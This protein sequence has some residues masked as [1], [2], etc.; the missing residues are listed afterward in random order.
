VSPA[1]QGLCAAVATACGVSRPT[2][3]AGRV[4]WDEFVRLV[5]RHQVGTLV[6][7]S[8]WLAEVGA[9][10]GAHAELLRRVEADAYRW[11]RL[12]ALLR[13]VLS[14]LADTGIDVV[15]LKGVTAALDGHGDPSARSSGDLDVL[16]RPESVAAAVSALRSAGLDWYGW[17]LPEDP[18][19]PPVGP[20]A[21][22]RPS[23]LPMLRD[24]TLE[25]DGFQVEI[26]WKLFSNPKLMP[27]DPDWLAHPRIQTIQGTEVPALPL[28]A[29]WLYVLVH[30]SN[31]RWARMK[32]LADV[33]ALAVRHPQLATAAA[34][35][36]AGEGYRRSVATGL[37]V[38][39]ATLGRFLPPDGRAWAAGAG[40]T[41][42]LVRRARS[43]VQGEHD[44]PRRVT[45]RALPG[46]VL[47]RLALRTDARYR[48]DEARLLLLAAGRAQA[49]EN[50]GLREL[51]AGPLRWTRRTAR[52]LAGRGG[53]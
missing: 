4:D 18:D 19:R 5:D 22:G 50:P 8:G 49:V 1:F 21:V 25:R 39:E 2:R 41:G 20:A 7:R 13:Q 47:G 51:A 28:T 37:L 43:A 42:L 16:V 31:H 3:P 15:V 44:L 26:H 24:V 23:E 11:L 48:L 29:H 10:A 35:N 27:L 34:L 17:S 53:P 45:P 46:E 30:G 6:H 40:G 38:A 32:W 12:A 9:P 52:R 14:V 36:A 33:P